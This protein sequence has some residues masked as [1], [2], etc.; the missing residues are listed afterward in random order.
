MTKKALTTADLVPPP[1]V[2]RR[3]GMPHRM[4]KPRRQNLRKANRR[5]PPLNLLRSSWWDWTSYER[6][7]QRRRH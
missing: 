2:R 3:K 4:E 6:C 7:D 5:H 1:L